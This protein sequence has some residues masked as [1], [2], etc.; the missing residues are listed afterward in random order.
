MASK[1]ML[2]F[3]ALFAVELNNLFTTE[4]AWSGDPKF[5]KL[6][7]GCCAVDADAILIF[8]VGGATPNTFCF[9]NCGFDPFTDVPLESEFANFT[10][11]AFL[12]ITFPF[13]FAIAFTASANV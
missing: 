3:A 6:T 4:F 7:T 5:S 9:E 2:L 11:I 13:I 1:T 10:S 8:A 12:C